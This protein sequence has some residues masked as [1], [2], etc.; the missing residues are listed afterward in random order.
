[1]PRKHLPTIIAILSSLLINISLIKDA[2]S[3]NI[4]DVDLNQKNAGGLTDQEKYISDN[5]LADKYAEKIKNEECK[6][7][8][9][10]C[11]GN[12][13]DSGAETI[14]AGLAKAYALVMGFVD[15]PIKFGKNTSDKTTEKAIESNAEKSAEKPA[16]KNEDSQMN[17]YCK[18][19]ATAT[20]TVA[21]FKQQVDQANISN[22]S[23]SSNVRELAQREALLKAARNHS[24]R[25]E[26]ARIQTIGWGSTTTCYIAMMAYGYSQGGTTLAMAKSIGP[27]IAASG[28]LTGFFANLMNKQDGYAKKVKQIANKLP[29]KGDCNPITDRDCYCVNENPTDATYCLPTVYQRTANTDSILTTCIDDN[30]KSDPTCQCKRTDTCYDQKY[31][32]LLKSAI[33]GTNQD[34]YKAALESMK[35]LANGSLSKSSVDSSINNAKGAIDKLKANI[36]SLPANNQLKLLTGEQKKIADFYKSQGIPS[37]IANSLAS[38]N[39]N[40]S[41]LP[42]LTSMLNSDE[43]FYDTPN[44]RTGNNYGNKVLQFDGSGKG[45]LAKDAKQNDNQLDFLNKLKNN[46]KDGKRNIGGKE[47]TFYSNKMQQNA[48]IHRGDQYSIFEIISNRYN[49]SGQKYLDVHMTQE[50]N[51]K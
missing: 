16:E 2:C 36:A 11:D 28:L 21:T 9:K 40:N 17:D 46:N 26:N 48:E 19:I 13:P 23:S 35:K 3:D 37:D 42:Q 7:K 18:Y 4:L 27:R 25:A 14:V 43:P 31:M 5:Y 33:P 51:Q 47:L 32:S 39:S 10:I 22:T 34:Y 8:E 45:Y 12:N 6:G 29:S 50:Q 15:L 41:N 24:S 30:L 49:K 38:T 44:K 1:M 20:E